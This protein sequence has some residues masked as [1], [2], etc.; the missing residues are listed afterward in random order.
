MWKGTD[1]REQDR[2]RQGSHSGVLPDARSAGSSRC[3]CA[4]WWAGCRTRECTMT[5]HT[6]VMVVGGIGLIG[7]AVVAQSVNQAGRDWP[8]HQGDQGGTRYS[9]LTQINAS[10]VKNL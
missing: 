2:P 7:A 6:I 8:Y 10:N 9:T 1:R 3:R 5:K 4:R